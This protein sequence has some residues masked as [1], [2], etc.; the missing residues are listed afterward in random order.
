MSKR[1]VTRTYPRPFACNP[2]WLG[3]A[4]THVGILRYAKYGLRTR[5]SKMAGERQPGINAS[6]KWFRLPWRCDSLS[7]PTHVSIHRDP[8]SSNKHLSCIT[9]SHLCG[10][11][12]LQNGR[13]MVL[14]LTTGLVARIHC[15]HFWGLISISGQE[16][17]SCFQLL[18]AEA[19]WDDLY[20]LS[21]FC[22]Y[23][24]RPMTYCRTKY[25]LHNS[26]H[27]SHLYKILYQ[28]ICT[29]TRISILS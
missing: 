23:I 22:L 21:C 29:H 14:S 16:L 9:T 27:L 1:R 7:E 12:F 25:S 4:R 11:P 19:T 20:P 2:S 6:Y 15:S 24:K 13:A 10:N 8:F 17:T 5:Q 28:Y 3:C 18:Q 26:L